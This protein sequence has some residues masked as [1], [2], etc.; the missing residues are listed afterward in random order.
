MRLVQLRGGLKVGYGFAAML[1]AGA[2]T[3]L[4]TNLAA[5]EVG[6]LVLRS[7]QNY[8]EFFLWTAHCPGI[9]KSQYT[10]QKVQCVIERRICDVGKCPFE[11]NSDDRPPLA[12]TFGLSLYNP[13]CAWVYDW[14]S[15][16]YVYRCW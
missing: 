11:R 9:N 5:Q 3:L 16:R 13:T 2:C 8:K 1:L 14:A 12:L 7:A 15:Y 10:E 4:P 6:F